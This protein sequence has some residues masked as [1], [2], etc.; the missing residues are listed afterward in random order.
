MKKTH[1]LVLK[2]SLLTTGIIIVLLLSAFVTILPVSGQTEKGPNI[3]TVRFIHSEDENLALQEIKSGD[4]DLYYFRIPLEAVGDATNDPR[5]TVYD[6]VAGSM[7]LLV[8]PAPASNDNQLNPFQ[9]R[10]V[11]Y[12][13]NYLI[14]REFLVNEVLKGYGSALVDPFGIYSPEYPNVIDVVES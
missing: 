10:E 12:A 7:G 13:L 3:D 2:T 6:R 4:L 14:N 11:R 8:N 9:S 5:L 1:M